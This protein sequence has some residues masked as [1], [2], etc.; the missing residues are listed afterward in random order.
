MFIIID[1]P[2][3]SMTHSSVALAG[4]A[5]SDHSI[6]HPLL[7]DPKL[8]EDGAEVLS[9]VSDIASRNE[10][11]ANADAVGRARLAAKP[12]KPPEDWDG[13]TCYDCGDDIPQERLGMGYCICVPCKSIQEAQDKQRR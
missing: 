3:S 5:H 2:T 1:G 4:A 8:H 11:Q 9:D 10:M 12:P 7:D 13:C 6:P